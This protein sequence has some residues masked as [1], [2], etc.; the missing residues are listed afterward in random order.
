MTNSQRDKAAKKADVALCKLQD[1]F[2][3]DTEIND[4]IARKL[5]EAC[6]KV[7]E[8]LSEIESTETTDKRKK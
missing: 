4:R 1:L 5:N 7:R 3:T 6:D 8:L 2:Y